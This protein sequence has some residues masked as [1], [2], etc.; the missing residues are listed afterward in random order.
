MTTKEKILDVALV[1]FAQQGVDK[2]S[3]AQ[4]TKKA[5]VAEGTLFVHFKSKQVRVD[6]VYIDIKEREYKAFESVLSDKKSAEENVR[7]LNKKV[8]SYFLEHTN[9]LQFVLHVKRLDLISK[10]AK[11][12]VAEFGAVI[13]NAMAS[14]QKS[15]E[16]KKMDLEL[17]GEQTWSMLVATIMYCKR[18]NKKVT[19]QIVAPI[20]DALKC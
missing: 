16:I 4:I 12:R 18:T 19:D 14:W 7:T 10:K 17:L 11:E 15:G 6:E 1:L 3:T 8:I 20:W 2:T 5:G 9:E 13:G